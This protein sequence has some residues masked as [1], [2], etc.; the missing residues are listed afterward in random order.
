MNASKKLLT[1][2]L[3]AASAAASAAPGQRA[4]RPP[5][6]PPDVK[7]DAP[8]VIAPPES[9]FKMIEERISNPRRFGRGRRDGAEQADEP[10]PA[11][12]KTAA[13]TAIYRNFY[14]KYLDVKGMPVAAHADVADLALQRTYEI[15]TH[16]LAGRPDL[17]QAM[18]SNHTY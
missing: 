15:V 14:K 10:K 18:V 17:L 6:D 8:A 11:A 2:V 3:L 16:L 9:F 1:A 13:E 4:L 7:I 12:E 5:M